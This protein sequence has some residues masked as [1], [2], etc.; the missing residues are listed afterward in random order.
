MRPSVVEHAKRVL[1]EVGRRLPMNTSRTAQLQTVHVR[2][3]HRIRKVRPAVAEQQG[4]CPACSGHFSRAGISVSTEL[5]AATGIRP[6]KNSLHRQPPAYG[7][8]SRTRTGA[9]GALVQEGW[10]LWAALS[11]CAAG[12]QVR[13]H[14]QGG[15]T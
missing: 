7:R 12:G 11:A 8:Q 9:V 2:C 15:D 4:S 10:P 13:M 14:P 1:T 6:S 3:Q 5:Q